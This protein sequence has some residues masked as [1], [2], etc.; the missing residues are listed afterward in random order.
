MV[1]MITKKPTAEDYGLHGSV[2]A[3]YGSNGGSRV[4]MKRLQQAT[5]K[6]NI[7]GTIRIRDFG[8]YEDGDA[9]EIA[10]SFR[11]LDYG[12]KVGYNF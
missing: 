12:I 7:V 4:S 10:S 3:G 1:N 11:S 8:K 6:C 5:E 9:M 2:D